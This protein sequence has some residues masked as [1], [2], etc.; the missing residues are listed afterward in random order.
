MA[1]FSYE[2]TPVAVRPDIAESHREAW[3]VLAGPGTW[4]AAA[5]RVAIAERAR[6]AFEQ[7]G[8]PPWL[9]Q[10]AT[11]GPELSERVVAI[12]DKLALDAGN[13]DREWAAKAIADIGDG[14]YVE[15][16]ATVATVVMIDVFAEA[17]GVDR[18]PVPRPEPGEPTRIRPDGLGD[19]G[20]YVPVLHPFPAANV[21]RA[22]SL[23][24]DANKL[25]RLVSVPTYSAPGF[26]SL[27]WETPLSRPQVELIAT[28]VAAMNECFY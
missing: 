6:T 5:E 16:V 19:I 8:N 1:P 14:P 3:T 27:Q 24:P 11:P 2:T 28:R 17:V 22:L 4:W 15:L 25:F 9:R 18:A 26:A 13:V 10:L 7:R 12:V 21:A 23:V 20:A